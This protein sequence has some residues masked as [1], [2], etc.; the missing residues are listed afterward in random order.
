MDEKSV[1]Q[2]NGAKVEMSFW[3]KADHVRWN[4]QKKKNVGDEAARQEGK[5]KN[6]Q[7][8]GWM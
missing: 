5:E 7:G 1:C 8:R 4:Q 3:S 6:Y 2:R